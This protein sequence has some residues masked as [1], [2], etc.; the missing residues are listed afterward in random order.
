MLNELHDFLLRAELPKKR[1]WLIYFNERR[2][3]IKNSTLR[4]AMLTMSTIIKLFLA[5]MSS[6]FRASV[7]EQRD[8]WYMDDGALT[9]ILC[10]EEIES[11]DDQPEILDECCACDEAKYEVIFE[12]LWSKVSHEMR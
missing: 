5:V 9:K 8:A 1:Q 12:G 11:F 3:H 7:V 6:V 4:N 2:A 10:E